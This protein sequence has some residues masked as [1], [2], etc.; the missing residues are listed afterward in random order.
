M[1]GIRGI[2]VPYYVSCISLLYNDIM[3]GDPKK[4]KSKCITL[5]HALLSLT[6]KIVVASTCVCI[7]VTSRVV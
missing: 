4:G 6:I 1:V 5:C 2:Q 7:N 3:K